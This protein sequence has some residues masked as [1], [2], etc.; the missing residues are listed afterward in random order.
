MTKKEEE[1]REHI[2]SLEKEKRELQERLDH[3]TLALET[4]RALLSLLDRSQ[5]IID[6]C[7]RVQ[8]GN[9][10]FKQRDVLMGRVR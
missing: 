3:V 9:H 10:T 8:L 2:W 5:Q 4:Q 6:E 7:K 1:M